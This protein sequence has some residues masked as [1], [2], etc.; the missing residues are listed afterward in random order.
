MGQNR[1]SEKVP[2][3]RYIPQVGAGYSMQRQTAVTAYF[4]SKQ[5]LLFAFALQRQTA[6]TA[7]FKNEQL[8][9]FVCAL[10]D[11]LLPSSNGILTALLQRQA[12][13]AAYL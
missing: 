11:S 6:V 13:V 7:Y 1:S 3:P 10:Q 12:A 2:G 4:T 9:L 5:L 8:L